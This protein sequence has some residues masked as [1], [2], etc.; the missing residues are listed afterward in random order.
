MDKENNLLRRR[1]GEYAVPLLAIISLLIS[2]VVVSNKKFFWNDELLSFYLLSDPS[3]THMMGAWGD[4]FNQAPPLYFILG[5]LW[6]KFLGTTELS[7]RLF[8]S[9]MICIALTLVW[10]VLRRTYN[11]W[12]ASIGALSTFCLSELV[13]YHNAEVRMYGLFAATCALG[14]LQFD[15]INR[16]QECSW[17]I[18][19]T[20]TLIHGS[21]VLTHLFGVLYSGAILFAFILRDRYFRVFRLKVYLSIILGWMFLI[22]FIPSIVHQSNNHAK[23]F[24]RISAS[25]LFGYYIFTSKLEVLFLF[26]LLISIFMYILQVIDKRG[27]EKI[28]ASSVNGFLDAEFSLLVLAGTFMLVPVIAWI[29][30]RT[31]TPLLNERYIIPTT[32][33]S[34]SIILAYLSSRILPIPQSTRLTYGKLNFFN[35]QNLIL[36]TLILIFIISPIRY[37]RH[38][39]INLPQGFLEKPGVNDD[40]YGYTTL[41][42]AVELGHDFLT[43]FHYSPKRNRYFHILDWENALKDTSSAFA[44]GDYTHLAALKRHY[45]FINS[46]QGEEFLHKYKRFL[47]LNEPEINRNWFEVKIKNNSMYKVRFL[48]NVKGQWQPLELFLVEY[49]E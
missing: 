28:T 36:S 27:E 11:F 3:F 34:W 5:W 41:P 29:I 35:K 40:S 9:V 13:L 37:A 10:I 21:I 33:I 43:R 46:I 31:I 32:A 17:K 24:S 19:V 15:S 42:I 26:L 8:S 20:N 44:T 1:K 48:G 49:Q 4:T 39:E 6:A 16:R 30:S 47:V 25:Q 12:A 14:L 22:P 2:C 45:N 38:P 23:W 7:L 18:S